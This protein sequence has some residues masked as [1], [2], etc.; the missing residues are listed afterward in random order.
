MRIAR[1]EAS[2]PPQKD[3][4]RRRLPCQRSVEDGYLA[5][6]SDSKRY[7]GKAVDDRGS[8]RG[9]LVIKPKTARPAIV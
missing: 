3:W 2:R 9:C 4:D 8:S 5:R 1:R 7:G 6:Q